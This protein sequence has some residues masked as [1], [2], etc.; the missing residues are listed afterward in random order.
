MILELDPVNTSH[1]P[2][3]TNLSL[4]NRT[5]WRDTGGKRNLSSGIRGVL[6]GSR[7]TYTYLKIIY[8]H[9]ILLLLFSYSCP[10]FFPCRF[11]MS[12][13]CK[14]NGIRALGFAAHGWT[15]RQA[16]P[17]SSLSQ[18]SAKQPQWVPPVIR[19][20]P[21]YFTMMSESQAMEM[22]RVRTEFFYM[23]SFPWAL[24]LSLRSSSSTL[25]LLLL[26]PLE[27]FLIIHSQYSVSSITCSSL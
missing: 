22:T 10:T 4:V 1:L 20:T 15:V 14:T 11:L 19:V 13:C 27:F 3:V 21:I 12:S 18:H 2:A 24:G 26:S 8:F 7:S 16:A 17:L 9:F 5:H 6:L 25:Y 23:C